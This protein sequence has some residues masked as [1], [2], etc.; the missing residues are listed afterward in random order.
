MF[1]ILK[2]QVWGNNGVTQKEQ[3]LEELFYEKVAD[4]MGCSLRDGT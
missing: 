1:R 4:V 3:K 2:S